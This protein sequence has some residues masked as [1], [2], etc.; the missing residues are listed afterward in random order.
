MFCATCVVAYYV[1]CAVACECTSTGAGAFAYA[2][3]MLNG[4]M[5]CLQ[6]DLFDADRRSPTDRDSATAFC[7]IYGYLSSDIL[8]QQSQPH[9]LYASKHLLKIYQ[10]KEH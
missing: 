5:G 8:H 2:P 4:V 1:A 3:K 7:Y 10:R 6:R 9:S